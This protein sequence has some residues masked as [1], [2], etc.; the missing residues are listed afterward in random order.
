M[1]KTRQVP[2]IVVLGPQ[3]AGKGTQAGRLKHRLHI[4][5]ISAGDVL[6]DEIASGSALGKKIAVIINTGSMLPDQLTNT[7]MKKRLQEPDIKR[8]WIVDGYPRSMEQAR[9]FQKSGEPNIVV[10]LHFLDR[11]AVRRLSGRRVCAKG[12][13]YHIL[14]DRPKKKRGHCDHDGLPLKQRDDDTPTAIRKRLRIYHQRTEPVIAWYRH[15]GLVA[16]VDA[17][18]SIPLVYRE[19]IRKLKRHFPWLSLPPQRT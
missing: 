10:Y 14:H 7:M 2:R 5:H 3:G 16:E 18:R 4:P 12:H 15:H 17:S 1:K 9:P 11:E 8:G 19:L 6:R 13:I